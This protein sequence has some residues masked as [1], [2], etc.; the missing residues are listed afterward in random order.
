M[1]YREVL[2]D[3]SS[4]TQDRISRNVTGSVVDQQMVWIR[5]L[6]E[7]MTDLILFLN[8]NTQEYFRH[9][10]L[11]SHLDDLKKAISD[12]KEFFNCENLNH[13]HQVDEMNK[14]IQELELNINLST[15]WYLA[16]KKGGGKYSGAK[17]KFASFKDKIQV[18]YV[19]ADPDQKL[20][21][22]ITYGNAYGR[23]S[24]SLH[25]NFANPDPETDSRHIEIGISRIGILAAHILVLCR[26]LLKDKR[27]KGFVSQISRVIRTNRYPQQIMKNRVNPGI[28]RGDFVIAYR[29][30]A[31]VVK[32]NKSKYGY[33]SFKVKYLAKPPLSNIPIDTFP[34]MF[35]R[36]FYDRKIIANQVKQKI[37]QTTPGSNIS[38]KHVA[39]S[40]RI[41]M[42]DMW[43]KFGF[44]ERYYGRP[45]LA[46]KKID[47]YLKTLKEESVSKKS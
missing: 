9:F 14:K 24:Q 4:E 3:T 38:T 22:E 11:I 34:A 33:R 47:D 43:E 2:K 20:T 16:G 6:I 17:C 41:T 46:S 42:A 21:L 23:S 40:L 5:K 35:V 25:P 12:S 10:L 31:E 19:K 30:I 7:I 28:K 27:R 39:D 32:V 44:K 8:T 37:M 29:D 1:E 36:K 13:K 26:K 18:A 15:C 45:Y